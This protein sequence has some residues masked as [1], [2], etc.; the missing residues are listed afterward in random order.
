MTVLSWG[1]KVMEKRRHLNLRER[2]L[3]VPKK[4]GFQMEG[5]WIWC[6]SV[7]RG[8][9][10]KYH[11]F[12]S[13]WKKTQRMH[14]G[15]LLESEVVRAV[16]ETPEGPYRYEETVLPPR[17]P[18][19]WDGRATHNPR[20]IKQGDTYY[21]FYTGI[22]HPF[23]DIPEGEIVDADDPRVT[24]SRASKRI[25]V[26]VAKSVYGPWERLDAPIINVRPKKFDS[27]L[28][29]NPSPLIEEDGSVWMMY[30]SRNY[31][32]APYKGV[33]HGPMAIGVAKGEDFLGPYIRL[34]ENAIF[35][36]DEVSIE[37]PF[38]WKENGYY[39]M[40]AKDMT[41][42]ICGEKYGGVHGYSR[43]GLH[44]EMC[45]GE[46]AFSRKI[47]WDDG[48]E[49]IM[50][51]MDRPF[52]LFEEGRAVCMFFAVSDGTDS[53]YDAKNTWNMAV[54]MKK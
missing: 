28:V 40:I 27:F 42:K 21:L 47:L 17:G 12:A 29:S 53:F 50:G 8:E 39:E 5:Y 3:P 35:D 16:S 9:D 7:I 30:K 19:Y 33:L 18:Q 10:G 4:G 45:S 25:G 2:M 54:P 11:M 38:V 36:I 6:G 52:I 43:D 41:G 1:S 24:V 32:K 51:N 34:S 26:A 44:W 14:P 20:V 46:L 37:D 48:T 15:W 22:T 13:R 31:K 49:Q 23:E